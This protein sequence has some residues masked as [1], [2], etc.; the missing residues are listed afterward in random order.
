M[1]LDFS[2][3]HRLAEQDTKVGFVAQ[4]F[5]F[6]GFAKQHDIVAAAGFGEVESQIG[7]L[8]EWTG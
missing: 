8:Q 2:F 5:R 1:H 6:V 4:G 3:P 7:L